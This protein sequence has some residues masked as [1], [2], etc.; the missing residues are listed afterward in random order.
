EIRGVRF[1]NDSKG[2]NVG[3]VVKSLQSFSEPVTLIAGGKDKNGDLSPLEA[4]IR[5]RVKHLVLIGEAKERMSRELGGLTHTVTA[6]TMEE[7]V[8]LAH[9]KAKAGEIV[10]LSPACSSFDMFKDYKE[11]GRVFKEAV[12]R[13]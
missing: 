11:R 9:R 7:A 10:L 3:S 6:K 8:L 12:R 4:L 5:K 2:T 13:L 1:Y